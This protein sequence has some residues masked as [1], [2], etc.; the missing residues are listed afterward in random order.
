MVDLTQRVLKFGKQ[1]LAIAFA[2]ALFLS[3]Q[4]G[5]T[6][7]A[8]TPLLDPNDRLDVV[9][10]AATSTVQRQVEVKFRVFDNNQA[11]VA[12]RIEIYDQNCAVKLRTIAN[13]NFKSSQ[14]YQVTGWNT[15]SG[16]GDGAKLGNGT[17][18]F[19][20]CADYKQNATAYNSCNQRRIIIN[21]IANRAPVIR[22][23]PPT[24]INKGQ[25]YEYVVQAQDPDGQALTYRLTQRP[26]F[27]SMTGNRVL[28]Q[29]VQSV[30]RFNVTVEV[31]DTFGATT[32]QSYTLTVVDPAIVDPGNGGTGGEENQPIEISFIYPQAGS[33]LS[34]K[35]NNV[36]WTIKDAKNI[37]SLSLQ[38]RNSP[39][40]TWAE[41]HKFAKPAGGDFDLAQATNYKW[42]VSALAKGDYQLRLVLTAGT[43]NYEAISPVFTIQNSDEGGNTSQNIVIYDLAPENGG[44]IAEKQPTLGAKIN[45]G[46]M[47][48][49]QASQI[50]LKL[51]DQDFANNCTLEK[52]QEE[53]VYSLTCKSNVD[54]Q[55]GSYKAKL[56]I[57]QPSTKPDAEIEVLAER[58]WS[59]SV[60]AS[61]P[62]ANDSEFITILGQRISRQT[63]N[64]LL[65]ICT[66]LLCLLLIPLLLLSLWRRRRRYSSVTETTT[67]ETTQDA[68]DPFATWQSSVPVVASTPSYDQTYGDFSL[69]SDESTEVKTP[70]VGD[71]FSTTSV[72][73]NYYPN[74]APVPAATEGTLPPLAPADS[75]SDMVSS[76][77]NSATDNSTTTNS[78]AAVEPTETGSSL[79]S[80]MGAVGASVGGWFRERAKSATEAA[81]KLAKRESNDK[82]DSLPEPSNSAASSMTDPGGPIAGMDVAKTTEQSSSTGD[83]LAGDFTPPSIDYNLNPVTN[84]SSQPVQAIPAE[85]L[86]S[87]PLP[88][89]NEMS[90]AAPADENIPATMPTPAVEAAPVAAVGSVPAASTPVYGGDDLPDWLKDDSALAVTPA[91]DATSATSLGDQAE[92]DGSD[93]YGFGD[94]TLGS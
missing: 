20:I 47:S 84:N 26:A 9:S 67:T 34:G 48:E 88:S 72:T 29:N 62:G 46:Q 90:P 21:N 33:I 25:N 51:N 75:N 30:G 15:E 87:T 61:L 39:D 60:V 94:Q 8:N 13:G 50:Q 66:A 18:C 65:T 53:K 85:D 16:Y 86:V 93:P 5:V 71:A 1:L 3:G 7:A 43:R 49:L 58:E 55:L 81:S 12:T 80:R 2:S 68:R 78:I 92:D 14:S 28:A 40:G 57:V 31:R 76:I 32:K 10:P 4:L 77:N 36:Q 27:L 24:T 38:Y 42:D 22:S 11:K 59:F 54:L 52:T 89:V 44:A 82:E 17:Y 37:A 73:N 74:P 6:F 83:I 23:T 70:T 45:I 69:A 63:L 91:N 64:L 35:D 56:S 19:S 41:L 79:M